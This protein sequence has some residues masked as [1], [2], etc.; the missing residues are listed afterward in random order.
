MK[1]VEDFM[2]E[3]RGAKVDYQVILYGGAVHAFTNP[4]AGEDLARGAAYNA[5]ADRRS[6]EAMKSFFEEIFK[7]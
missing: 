5:K 6:W 1:Q 3:M 2:D 7:P 4:D